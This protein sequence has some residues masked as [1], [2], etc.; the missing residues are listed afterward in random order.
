VSTNTASEIERSKAI[1]HG[2]EPA[3]LLGSLTGELVLRMNNGPQSGRVV[4]LS[5]TKCSI[6]SASDCTLRLRG[7]GIDPVH[8]VILR[9][10]RQTVI[11]RW[12]TDTRLNDRRFDDVALRCGD[13]L[14][15]GPIEMQVLS[16]P[17]EV[18]E[19]VAAAVR[20]VDVELAATSNRLE[21]LTERLNLANRQG[22][23]RLRAVLAK[24]RKYQFK[25]TEV[26]AR[27]NRT[28]QE[29]EQLAAEKA[30]LAAAR[31]TV[32]LRRNELES[33]IR[34]LADFDATAAARR[35]ELDRMAA[36]LAERDAAITGRSQKLDEQAAGLTTEWSRLQAAQADLKLRCAEWE[37]QTHRL[38]EV[39]NEATAR[40]AELDRQAATLGEREIELRERTRVVDERTST[41]AEAE[42]RFAD[43]ET[44]LTRQVNDLRHQADELT[45]REAEV[46]GRC[47]ALKN[48]W[49]LLTERETALERDRAEL[50]S[51]EQSL[52]E[53]V[54]AVAAAASAAAAAV[55]VPPPA[56]IVETKIVVDSTAVE[57]AAELQRALDNA[58]GELAMLQAEQ[59]RQTAALHQ[60]QAADE[61]ELIE[62]RSALEAELADRRAAVEAEAADLAHRRATVELAA[63]TVERRAELVDAWS[64][65]APTVVETPVATTEGSS[66]PL[67][68]AKDEMA[69]AATVASL[70]AA[71]HQALIDRLEIDKLEAELKTW[72]DEAKLWKSRFDELSFAPPAPKV[73]TN[74]EE[75]A[76]TPAESTESSIAAESLAEEPVA[77]EPVAEQA[78]VEEAVLEDHVA[79]TTHEDESVADGEAE[80]DE[81]VHEPEAE[82]EAEADVEA[83]APAADVKA[84][85]AADVLRRLGLSA[86][87]EEEPAA[88]AA[89]AR[90]PTPPPAP[91]PQPAPAAHHEGDESLDD[92]MQ[93]LF[94]RLG[95]KQGAAPV[96]EPPPKR[97]M[98]SMPAPAARVEEPTNEK[99]A[100]APPA[101]P[102]LQP[103]EFKARSVAAERKSDFTALR[104]LANMQAKTAITK[105]QITK[106]SSRSKGK[107][108]IAILSTAMTAYCGWSY[109]NGYDV[110]KYGIG[111]G[112]LTAVLFAV[113]AVRL[114][115]KSK[116]SAR[117]LD[118]VLH[119]S[120]VR[121]ATKDVGK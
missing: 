35:A 17:G 25:L 29:N 97:P 45:R 40:R 118:D 79:D 7:V 23:R 69:A 54:A 93:Q 116:K 115:Q 91:A 4:R 87:L 5:S 83:V 57:R 114:K 101:L 70:Y 10:A 95:V 66:A 67:E 107:L 53:Q 110:A 100:E 74:H 105:H 9:G 1:L 30:E 60:R 78:S 42:R 90:Q 28:A 20:K 38:A 102:P 71:E 44:E 64:A 94:Q 77:E 50:T 31:V 120:A 8:C 73:E 98:M 36:Q 85:S 13:R 81:Y 49:H 117:S 47:E 65:E 111:V 6:G 119:K 15:V 104:E 34:K 89:P 121:G 76:I 106:Q 58:R 46:A 51:R 72:R 24:L 32:E 96:A 14:A 33:E 86:G 108:V 82:A 55:P 75:A 16:V 3:S 84:E 99:S 18:R 37:Q 92:Y 41:L 22:R 2:K 39:E 12:S 68:E 26:E 109:Y 103:E 63:R 80:M 62:R 11:R 52:A 43:R 113:Q 61:V 19:S 48:H 27:R 21:R 112:I 88:N 59:A 56:P